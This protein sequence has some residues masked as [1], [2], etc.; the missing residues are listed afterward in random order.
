MT[1]TE[2]RDR[3]TRLR[4]TQAILGEA[5]S[6]SGNTIARWERGELEIAAPKMLDLALQQLEWQRLL[7]N[8]S[9]EMKRRV[10]ALRK[11]KAELQDLAA[12]AVA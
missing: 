5:L 9:R 11:I 8:P 4:M 2:L 6:V 10:S 12:S 1:G 3:R 7:D